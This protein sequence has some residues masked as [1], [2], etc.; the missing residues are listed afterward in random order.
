MNL[1]DSNS[2]DGKVGTSPELQNDSLV[3]EEDDSSVISEIDMFDKG[4]GY[5]KV[6]T[7]DDNEIFGCNIFEK[8]ET[9]KFFEFPDQ[10]KKR[11]AK[12]NEIYKDENEISGS[13]ENRTFNGTSKSMLDKFRYSVGNTKITRFNKLVRNDETNDDK[14]KQICDN[15]VRKPLGFTDP[16][17]RSRTFPTLDVKTKYR[18]ISNNSRDRTTQTLK[19]NLKNGISLTRSNSTTRVTTISGLD[20]TVKSRK[21][22]S[23]TRSFSKEYRGEDLSITDTIVKKTD[24]NISNSKGN[25]NNSHDLRP[26][27]RPISLLSQFIYKQNP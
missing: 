4:L 16:N 8:D 11:K 19:S 20:A 12:I 7:K 17:I 10:I 14:N 1:N 2:D 6:K 15:K 25:E 21:P 22:E 18:S 23:L 5:D 3:H 13:I 26:S 9:I 27:S 24:A